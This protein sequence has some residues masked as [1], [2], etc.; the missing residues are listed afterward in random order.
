M[1]HCENSYGIYGSGWRFDNKRQNRD[2]SRDL[3][4][5]TEGTNHSENLDTDGKIIQVLYLIFKK[6]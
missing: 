5:K 1:L 4:V 6:E 3:V 2:A